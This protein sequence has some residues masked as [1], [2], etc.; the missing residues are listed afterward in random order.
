M[1]SC[2]PRP[3]GDR[4]YRGA[5]LLCAV[6]SGSGLVRLRLVG[7]RWSAE[8][9]TA[10]DAGDPTG[11]PGWHADANEAYIGAANL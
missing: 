9:N 10:T 1:T 8:R 7:R 11:S 6:G 4:G 3:S 5:G 2:A